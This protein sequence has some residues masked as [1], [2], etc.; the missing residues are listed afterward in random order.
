M[1]VQLPYKPTKSPLLGKILAALKVLSLECNNNSSLKIL[2]NLPNW[3][4]QEFECFSQKT[5]HTFLA[6]AFSPFLENFIIDAE[7]FWQARPAKFLRSGIWTEIGISG[8]EIHL[9]A[10]A[11]FL[12]GRQVILIESSE[13]VASEK[14]KWLQT[15][16]QD[17]LNFISERKI[18][19]TQ[20]LS[21]TFYDTLTKL[22]NRTLFLS[23]LETLFE[24]D[25]KEHQ[26]RLAAVVLNLDRFQ[27]INH[28]LGSTGGDQVLI[29]IAQ[30][31]KG[32]LRKEDILVR[33]GSDEFGVL[34]YG[35]ENEQDAS[36]TVK[37]IL[38][39]IH[40]PLSINNETLYI[41]ASAGIA[42]SET[43]YTHSRDLL[44]DSSLAMHQAKS[45]G[46]GRFVLF[47][48]D[49]HA[50]A[51]ELWSL[52]SDLRSTIQKEELQLWFQPIVDLKTHCIESFEA[53]V[54]WQHPVH[55]WIPPAKF[56]PLAEE[57]GLITAIDD[58]VLSAACQAIQHCQTVTGQTIRLNVN[59][60]AQHFSEGSL[61][62][63]VQAAIAASNITPASLRLEI[64][65]SLLLTDTT[66][67]IATLNQLKALGIEIAI[68][69]FGTGYAS[70]SYLQALPLDKLKI[71]GYFI[72][73]MPTSGPKIVKTIIQL[74]HDL[75]FGVT[76]ERVE[77]LEQYHTLRELGCDTV[78]GYLFSKPVP[79][80]KAQTLMKTN[81][82]DP[83]RR[84]NPL[85]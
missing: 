61:F 29:E 56:I 14:F 78:Q 76:A 9:E 52:E 57:S 84:S 53:L 72:E 27:Q 49:M 67:A 55:G 13:P 45:F 37:R 65:E 63:K 24:A 34:L 69:D 75:G 42:L 35:V 39:S 77:T 73:M 8:R 51:F 46:R 54:R 48:H 60:S 18:A 3:A 82:L 4:Q 5:E 44:R 74:A 47:N 20:I 81:I 36:T 15:A 21:A 85:S 58:W 70:F 16:R 28:N 62:P 11:L 32:C 19:T 68:D 66:A 22:P 50:K 2:G 10:I 38:E 26:H 59:I 64:T 33:F 41:T 12:E 6:E 23:Q 7:D 17:H 80:A 31:I 25:K 83:N 71:D 30:R 43:W 40:Q 1:P 79:I